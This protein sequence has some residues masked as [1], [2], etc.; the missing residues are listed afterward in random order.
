MEFLKNISLPCEWAGVGRRKMVCLSAA[1]YFLLTTCSVQSVQ[2]LSCVQ[3]FKT[4][5]IAARQ[6]SLSITDSQSSLKP[7]PSS[8][9]CHPAISSSVIP[10]SSCL[11]SL[12][13]SGFFPM[14]WLFTSGGQSTGASSL[15]SVLPMNIQGWFLSGLT[16]LISLQSKK[17]SRAFA[18]I[19][20]WRHQSLGAQPFLLLSFHIHT[21]LLEWVAISL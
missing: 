6:A 1:C 10:F 16:G 14:S 20:V 2:S 8:Q 12:L 17:L 9:W 18:S 15:A 11:Q 19:T 7:C 3:L 4:P 13:A 5:W 21:W